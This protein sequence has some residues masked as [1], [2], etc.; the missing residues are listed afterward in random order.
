MKK[1]LFAL[2]LLTS[3]AAH[4]GK[5]NPTDFPIAVHVQNSR[6]VGVCEAIMLHPYC[7]INLLLDVVIDGKKYQL[8]GGNWDYPLKLGDYKAKLKLDVQPGEPNQPPPYVNQ[9]RYQFLFDDGKT[10]NFKVIAE[11][12]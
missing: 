12:E 1:L 2:L 3:T 11:L 9:Q 10:V 4:A 6:L 5:P 7:S 8:N